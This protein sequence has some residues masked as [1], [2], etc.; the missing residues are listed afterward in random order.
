M[1]FRSILFPLLLLLVFPQSSRDSI[2]KHYETAEAHHRAG[3]FAGAEAE[4]GAILSEAYQK[5]GK[6]YFAQANYQGEASALEGAATY[7]PDSADVLVG[8]AIAYFHSEQYQKA[9]APLNKALAH[10][11][12]SV[13]A[14]HMLGKTLFMLGDFPKSTEEL[15]SAHK[16]SPND[17]D[18]AYTL[19]LA[20][21]KQ[22]QFAQAKQIYDGM[23]SQL[24]NRPQLRVLIGRAYRETGFLPES[25]TEFKSA[26]A[27]DPEFPRVHYY[28]GLTY[29][30]KDGAARLGDAAEEFKIELAT[31]PHEFFANYYLGILATIERNWSAAI[32]FLLEA[33]Q[34]QPNN[35]DPYFYLGQSYQGLQKHEEAIVV[36]R[37]TIALTPEL[38]HNDYQVTNAHYRLGQSLTKIGR[39]EEG[40][41]EL[42]I[43]AELKAQAFKRDEARLG[44]FINAV[45]SEEQKKFPELI[46]QNGILTDST[47]LDTQTIE[48]LKSDA[49]FYTKVIAVAYNNIGLLRAERQEFRSAAESFQL[50]ANSDPQIEGLSFNLG[51]A[52]YKAELYK[53]AV[54]PLEK[55]LK[56]HPSNTAAKQL[57]G[58]SYFMTD[59]YAQASTLL[60]EVINSKPDELTLYYPLALSLIK[61]RKTEEANEV[62]QHMVA[63]GEN[64]PQ[65]HML[66]GQAQYD[67][68]DTAKA[69]EELQQAL[70]LDSKVSLAHFYSGL[71]YLKLGKF[72][73]AIREFQAELALNPN[74]L[75]AKYHLAYVLLAH[76][77]TERGIKLIREV[78]RAKPDF[79]DARYELGKALLQTGD[80]KGAVENLEIAAKLDPEKPHVHYQLGRAY[81]AAGRQTE[82]QNELEISRQLKEKARNQ[83]NQ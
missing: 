10:N 28:L 5:L 49:A 2:R 39:G 75:Q 48:A 41:R 38:R 20:Y 15:Q 79:G 27:L 3:N 6:I 37:K 53:D 16:L 35:P 68:G 9:I 67:Q 74:D 56:D 50:A 1:S 8:L 66:L 21:L 19:G 61:Q 4:F 7:Q 23:I 22:R 70:S 57:L 18:V 82:G 32:G 45:S 12:E 62:I 69:L 25:I 71:I 80:I 73:D 81:V 40:E 42:Q 78:V 44:S 55:E 65:V 83:T 51:L 33:S 29:L 54:P 52:R 47:V 24:G 36:L 11:P 60:S 76:Q 64:S 72:D 43:A 26:I 46:S 77:E 31:H 59:R 30:L 58:L 63:S 34:I 14:H 13:A 17:Y